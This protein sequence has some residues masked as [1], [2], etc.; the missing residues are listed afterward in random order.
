MVKINDVALNLGNNPRIQA[1]KA[2]DTDN[3]DSIFTKATLNDSLLSFSIEKTGNVDT[4]AKFSQSQKIKKIVDAPSPKITINGEEK[5]ATYVV[6][7]KENKLYKYDKNGDSVEAHSI[8][9]GKKSSPTHSGIRI[10]TGVETY[11]YDKAPKGSKRRANPKAYGPNIIVLS[12]I[13][14]KTGKILGS[15]GEF[16]HGTSNPSSIGKY[17][18]HGCMRLPNEV[19]A[20][21]A[22]ETKKGSYVIIED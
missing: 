22:K 12:S 17:A 13:D 20:E 1:Q 5:I 14:P 7:L 2:S 11:P 19:I 3:S 6:S 15:N 16:I 8:A 18:S 4:I 10:V 21:L 9:S